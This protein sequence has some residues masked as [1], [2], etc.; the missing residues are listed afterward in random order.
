M[1][2]RAKTLP[3]QM[4]SDERVI[5]VIS[6]ATTDVQRVFSADDLGVM[7]TLASTYLRVTPCGLSIAK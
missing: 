2:S 4:I 6:V 5:A 3:I 1:P 7:Q